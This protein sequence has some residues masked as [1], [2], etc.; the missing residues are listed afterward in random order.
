MKKLARDKYD[1]VMTSAK[2]EVI[3]ITSSKGLIAC[4]QSPTLLKQL[5]KRGVTLK[6][7]A[8]ILNENLEAAKQLSKNHAVRHVPVSYLGTT[9]IDEKYLFQFKVPDSGQEENNSRPIF[10]NTYYTNDTRHVRRISTMLNNVWKNASI[11]SAVT[12]E[13]FYGPSLVT[14]SIS[15]SEGGKDKHVSSRALGDRKDSSTQ[16]PNQVMT[17]RRITGHALVHPPSFSACP[18]WRY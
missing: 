7:M 9:I 5:T 8:P 6:I 16:S 15:E 14:V 12:I 11:P 2:R 13:S 17:A 4:A 10:E 3:M 1:A 18:I